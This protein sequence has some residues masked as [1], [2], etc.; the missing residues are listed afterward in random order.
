M[1]GLIFDIKE[2]AVH[3]GDGVRTTV[4]FKGCPLRCAWCHNPEGL[5][6]TR[7]LY[8]RREGCLACGLC[9]RPCT[10]DDCKPFGRCLHVCP[11]DLIRPVGREYSVEELADKLL[12]QKPFLQSVGGGITLSGGE[13]LLQAAFCTELLRA[14]NG[15]LHVTLETSGYASEADFL[16]VT[17]LCDFV[18]MD[19]KLMDDQAHRRYTGISNERILHN[20]RLLM[21]S[22][23]PHL[24]R[25]PLIPGITD[26]E[27][28]LRAIAD[29]IGDEPIEL[30]SYNELAAAKY[31][32]V[33][34]IFPDFIDPKN[35]SDVPT[36]LFRGIVQKR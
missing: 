11:K 21:N 17:E 5:S 2:F 32:S 20:A 16:R 12:R 31:A 22:G 29:L 30:L 7:E 28:N 25:T 19:L 27:E 15:E 34:R 3:D 1:R 26:T 35:A 4:F 18:M 13:P 9:R 8:E 33:G 24:F 23:V 6:P 14:L 36:N 10:H